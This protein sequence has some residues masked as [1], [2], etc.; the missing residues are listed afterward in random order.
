MQLRADAR[1][2][3][4][5]LVDVL[6]CLGAVTVTLLDAPYVD[7]SASLIGALDLMALPGIR[8]AVQAVAHKARPAG[9]LVPDLSCTN[10]TAG[11]VQAAAHKGAP[12][13]EPLLVSLFIS[14]HG[15]LVH[16]SS[17]HVKA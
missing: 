10:P 4:A 12:L 3:L 9:A 11:A 14:V 5:P 15:S 16:W 1:I 6:P 7:L 17:S 8:D 13:L 2:T